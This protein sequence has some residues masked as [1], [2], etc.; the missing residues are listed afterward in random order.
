MAPN[1]P[2]GSAQHDPSQR[3]LST[4]GL[5][6]YQAGYFMGMDPGTKKTI[7]VR[8][9]L[10]PPLHVHIWNGGL[11]ALFG[12]MVSKKDKITKTSNNERQRR[13]NKSNDTW[14]QISLQKRWH[15]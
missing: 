4:D 1:A 8:S 7:P 2:S 13:K 14:P 5:V 15:H 9:K 12:S 11:L 3:Q 6:K 10:G